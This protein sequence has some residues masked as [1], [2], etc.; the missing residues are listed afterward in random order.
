MPL[1]EA[2]RAYA[3][4]FEFFLEYGIE[5]ISNVFNRLTETLNASRIKQ[6][7]TILNEINRVTKAN[8][9]Q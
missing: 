3:I 8:I 7:Y 2:N 5:H 9:I 1:D 6:D 4:A